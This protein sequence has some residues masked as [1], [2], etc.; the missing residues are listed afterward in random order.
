MQVNQWRVHISHDGAGSFMR[1]ELSIF[2]GCMSPDGA[3]YVQP[4][5]V[6]LSEAFPNGTT[7]IPEFEPTRLPVELVEALFDALTYTL[8]GVADPVREIALLRR[9]LAEANKRVDNLIS[10]IGR[11]GSEKGKI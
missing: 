9:Q 2:I 11:L 8:T 4:L 5:E 10:G 6:K 1:D 7:V 3:H